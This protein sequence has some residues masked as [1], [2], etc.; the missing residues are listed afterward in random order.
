MS[1]AESHP[2]LDGAQKS[3]RLILDLVQWH[4]EQGD[5]AARA[6]RMA[7][8][9]EIY[10]QAIESVFDPKG[11]ARAIELAKSGDLDA[12]KS[13]HLAISGYVKGS[14]IPEPLQ[15]Y[16]VELLWAQ[17][18]PGKP[19]TVPHKNYLRNSYIKQAVRAAMDYGF[20]RTRNREPSARSQSNTFSA[21]SIVA[22]ILRE[23][24]IPMTERTVEDIS[25]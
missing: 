24:N 4:L 10:Y 9:R 7:F 19:G 16:L 1:G 20:E 23:K 2:N 8:Q 22:D 15:E 3:A 17:N 14:D 18:T 12:R 6:G 13:V 11:V 25:E 21:C 5:D